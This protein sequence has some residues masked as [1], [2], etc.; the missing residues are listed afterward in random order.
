M[1]NPNHLPLTYLDRNM[2]RVGKKIVIGYWDRP[3]AREEFSAKFLES[4][5][6]ESVSAYMRMMKFLKEDRERARKEQGKGQIT[7]WENPAGKK[8]PQPFSERWVCHLS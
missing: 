6:I 1:D 5:C 2:E 8:W 7:V 4:E 3:E